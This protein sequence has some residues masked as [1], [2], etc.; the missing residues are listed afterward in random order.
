MTPRHPGWLGVRT[1]H[2]YA[3]RRHAVPGCGTSSTSATFRPSA[4]TCGGR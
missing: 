4:A 3:P 2:D 1:A